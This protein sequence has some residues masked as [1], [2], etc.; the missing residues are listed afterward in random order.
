[1]SE[2]L[3]YVWAKLTTTG[4]VSKASPRWLCEALSEVLQDLAANLKLQA[5]PSR[6]SSYHLNSSDWTRP[7]ARSRAGQHSHRRPRNLIKS[8]SELEPWFH[9]YR[10]FDF[11]V[12]QVLVATSASLG[13]LGAI[14]AWSKFQSSTQARSLSWYLHPQSNMGQVL[15]QKQRWEALFAQKK[16]RRDALKQDWLVTRQIVS[17]Q[18]TSNCIDPCLNSMLYTLRPS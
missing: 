4:K 2:P 18:G 8:S 15:T 16:E 7:Q 9:V 6:S 12:S 3:P 1:M 11:N 17:S 5:R 13:F 14:K 10:I